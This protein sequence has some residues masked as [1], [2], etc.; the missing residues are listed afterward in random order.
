MNPYIDS[1][2]ELHIP[3]DCDARYKW[4]RLEDEVECIKGILRELGREDLIEKYLF[5]P[6]K[7]V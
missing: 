5:S 4:W 7:G 3:F 2:D 6:E 1:K